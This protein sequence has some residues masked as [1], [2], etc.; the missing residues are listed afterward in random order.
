M[1]GGQFF[2]RAG[3]L[4]HKCRAESADRNSRGQV[5][6]LIR[7]RPVEFVQ[8]EPAWVSETAAPALDLADCES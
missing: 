6:R 7:A 3:D 8:Y 2:D 5:K 4:L 1:S